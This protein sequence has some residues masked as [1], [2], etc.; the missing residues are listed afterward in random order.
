MSRGEAVRV[1]A[2]TVKFGA[3]AQPAL[4]AGL[5]S[6]KTYLRHGCALALALAPSDEAT[7]AVIALL[8]REP[9]ELWHEIA[10]ANRADR[11][12]GAGLARARGQ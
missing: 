8:H 3:A 10:R 2:G 9:T 11:H 6:S 1:L 7:G 12:A 5:A 4:I